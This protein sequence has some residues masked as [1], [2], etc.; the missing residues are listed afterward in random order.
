MN[1]ELRQKKIDSNSLRILNDII[2]YHI[3]L[4]D[5]SLVTV[6]RLVASERLDSF[7]IFISCLPIENHAEV[8]KV[9]E[10]NRKI[11]SENLFQKLQLR[12]QPDVIFKISESEEA[13]QDLNEILDSLS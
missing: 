5:N 1:H 8:L 11:I 2:K 13:A 12:R 4:P 3:D 7:K 6:S 10:T 9:F